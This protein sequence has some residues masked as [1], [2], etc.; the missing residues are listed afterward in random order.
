MGHKDRFTRA[1]ISAVLVMPIL[2]MIGCSGAMTPTRQPEPTKAG[3]APAAQAPVEPAKTEEPALPPPPDLQPIE[4][5]QPYPQEVSPVGDAKLEPGYD[6]MRRGV[7]A[8]NYDAQKLLFESGFKVNTARTVVLPET[9]VSALPQQPS[10]AVDTRLVQINALTDHHCMFRQDCE[11]PYGRMQ[12]GGYFRLEGT[13]GDGGSI[14]AWATLPGEP[15]TVAEGLYGY[16]YWISWEF[17]GDPSTHCVSSFSIDFGPVTPLDYDWN[18]TP[19]FGLFYG[20]PGETPPVVE[21]KGN[22]LTFHYDQPI[23]A[24]TSEAEGSYSFYFSLTSAFPPRY[25][26]AQVQDINGVTYLPLSLAPDYPPT[27]QP[28]PG[29]GAVPPVLVWTNIENFNCAFAQNCK[30]DDKFTEGSFQLQGTSGN[31]AIWTAST[32]PGE[33]GMAAA[34]LYGYL[35]R[36]YLSKVIGNPETDCVNSFQVRFGPVTPLDYDHNGTP[37]LGFVE[38]SSV[39]PTVVE[40]TYDAI[41][42]RFDPP[43]CSGG[44]GKEYGDDSLWFGLASAYPPREINAQVQ[45]I[46]G[47]MYSDKSLAPDYPQQQAIVETVSIAPVAAAEDPNAFDQAKLEE[48]FR[49]QGVILGMLVLETNAP[50]SLIPP[51]AYLERAYLD[52]DKGVVELIDVTSGQTVYNVDLLAQ[53]VQDPSLIIPSASIFLGSKTCLTCL[54]DWYICRDCFFWEAGMTLEECQQILETLTP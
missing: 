25:I 30:P 36:V 34:G 35:Y 23:C 2:L 14:S 40:H 18:E 46:N 15:G 24:G 1:V 39:W 44:P 12:S 16:T 48:M 6:P 22:M 47:V 53:K 5:W 52:G 37:D 20:F 7:A 45:D 17:I 31:A 33:S 38:S 19:D 26:E 21:Q 9:A 50:N 28:G 41:S 10:L 32:R 51:G 8:M 49:T 43:L 11:D 3:E 13:S 42:F 54:W 29:V 4:A 27:V